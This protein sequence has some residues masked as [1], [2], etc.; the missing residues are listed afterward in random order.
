M[1]MKLVVILAA[2]LLMGIAEA[3]TCKMRTKNEIWKHPKGKFVNNPPDSKKWQ[4]YD[5]GGNVAAN[6]VEKL[7]QGNQ[8]VLHD[9]VC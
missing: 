3:K 9:A 7:R 5:E 8:L 4:E 6:F 2:I 1:S